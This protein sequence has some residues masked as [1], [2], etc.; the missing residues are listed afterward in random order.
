[1]CGRFMS[2]LA[3]T[4]L[5]AFFDAEAPDADLGERYNI[6]PSNHVYGV[7]ALVG[8]QRAVQVFEWGL[9]PSW[10]KDQ[11]I[12]HQ[13]INCRA[14]TM[15]EKPAFRSS[16][17]KRRCVI[18]MSGFYEWLPPSTDGPRNARGASVKRPLL[19]EP[20]AGRVLAAAGLWSVWREPGA[21]SGPWRHTC[22]IVTTCANAL[23][24]PV[25][26]RMPVLLD[27]D[28]WHE[29]LDPAA[30]PEELHALCQPAPEELL[31]VSP[32][33]AEV[34]NVRNRGPFR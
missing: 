26:D 25:H 5:A 30:R 16:F 4:E 6:A 23:M 11:R 18:P 7:V 9:I 22:T 24:S 15:A 21:V 12:G 17:T 33:S 31:M 19:F 8:G 13:L 27:D 2:S 20:R 32:V 28:G 14:E 34:N 10:A 3:G 29:W 1:M